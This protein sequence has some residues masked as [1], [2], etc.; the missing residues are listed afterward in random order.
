MINNNHVEISNFCVAGISYK[1]SDASCRGKYAVSNDQ[2]ASILSKASKYHLKEL[3]I[4]STCNRTEIYGFAESVE[5][6]CE[7]IC[8]ET[9]N[10]VESFKEVAYFKKEL[11]AVNHLFS[12]AA[13]LDS[14]I[15]GDYEV[16]GQIKQAVKFSKDLKFVGTHLER[17]INAV[18]KASKEIKTNT[19]LSGGT[20]SV[21]FAAV[22]FIKEN[23]SS[24]NDKKILLVGTGKI[25]KN[26]CKNLI[27]YLNTKNITLI[28][29]T[30]DK[31]KLL[32]EE[33]GLQYATCEELPKK[34]KDSD[35]ILLATNAKNPIIFKSH[36]ENHGEKLIIDLSVP[37]NVDAD[38]QYLSNVKLINV[39]DLSKIKDSTLLM[40]EQE[41]PK[42][43][44]IIQ[45]NIQ[46]FLEW[47]EMRKQV[48]VLNS[49]KTKLLDLPITNLQFIESM[50]PGLNITNNC[51][52]DRVQKIIDGL[53]VRIRE[54]SQHSNHYIKV[55]NDY[56]TSVSN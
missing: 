35:I 2:Y 46:E 25:G 9:N 15:L 17:L 56:I 33:F 28:N 27:D 14:Q 31:A 29:R 55:I 38:A 8:E 44:A 20:V 5:S 30:D 18:F 34:L 45:K 41:I 12:V 22:Q 6:F 42:V 52:E 16:I 50:C 49:V 51:K 24:L 43:K 13:G 48:S 54:H 37:Y 4:L 39:D 26:T 10:T 53:A 47:H 40:R 19:L 32:A 3:F 7:L 21:S 36:L 23:F 1:K 11:D